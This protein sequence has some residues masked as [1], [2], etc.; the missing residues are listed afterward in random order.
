MQR[1]VKRGE[2]NE[3]VYVRMQH[4]TEARETLMAIGRGESPTHMEVKEEPPSRV[5]VD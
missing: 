5:A 4:S 1:V 3:C 2:V